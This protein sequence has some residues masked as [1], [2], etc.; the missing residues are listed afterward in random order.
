MREELLP[1]SFVSNQQLTKQ[2]NKQKHWQKYTPF[3]E[4]EEFQFLLES[5]QTWKC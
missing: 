5:A 3:Q 2:P 1:V 4:M